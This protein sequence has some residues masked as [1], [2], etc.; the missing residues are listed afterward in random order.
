MKNI[1]FL[2]KKTKK[3]RISTELP[4]V[5]CKLFFDR[6]VV[7]FERG[8]CG[9]ICGFGGFMDFWQWHRYP[10]PAEESFRCVL[11]VIK[12]KFLKSG[13][14]SHSHSHQR[15]AICVTPLRK[16]CFLRFY[17]LHSMFCVL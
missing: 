10:F 12:D 6:F 13:R 8:V 15:G 7:S 9:K 2:E 1:S 14:L 17:Y 3:T 5:G 4:K 11:N 16:K